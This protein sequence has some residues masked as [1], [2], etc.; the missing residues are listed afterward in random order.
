MIVEDQ[1]EAIAFMATSRSDAAMRVDR[2]DTHT[3]VVFLAGERAYKMKRAV[4]F[5]YVDFS[6]LD[7]RERACRAEIQVNRRTAPSLYLGV[8]PVTRQSDGALALGGAGTVVEWLVEMRRFDG[9]QLFDRLAAD[10]QLDL[11]LMSTLGGAIARFHA[12]ASRREECGGLSG[13]AWVVDGNAAGFAEF[14]GILDPCLCARVS[15]G[16]RAE[17]DRHG[18]LLEERRGRG[19]VRECHGDLH[20]GNI[21]LLD[22]EPTL[23]D[24]IEFN[25]RISCIDVLY[26]LSFLLMDLWHRRLPRHANVVL[27]RYMAEAADLEGLR[28]LPL[29]L[30]CRAA[31]RAKTSAAGALVQVDGERRRSLEETAREYLALAADF[32]TAPSPRMLAVGGLSGSG[33]TTVAAALAPEIGAAPGAILL[34]SDE[35]RKQL[36]GVPLLE[37]LGPDSYTPSVSRLVYETLAT[38]ARAVLRAGHSVIVDAVFAEPSHR[39]DI[40]RVAR[41]ESA[42][43]R[44]CWLTAPESVLTARVEERRCDASDAT[45]DVVRQQYRQQTSPASWTVVDATGTR[46]EILRR[47]ARS[48]TPADLRRV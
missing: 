21:V 14:A 26:D 4:R 16:A 44:G 24:G 13:T 39:E 22:G 36:C 10:H 12:A 45:A 7:R 15:A 32:L 11:R 25:D 1:S 48:L 35:I 43:F 42:P 40:A 8:V 2:V 33:K 29:F 30:S 18:R 3:A 6:T 27:N 23:F 47:C 20:L 41:E 34:R 9:S 5:D 46:D 17:M 28:L 31:V 19:F 38:R 37:R